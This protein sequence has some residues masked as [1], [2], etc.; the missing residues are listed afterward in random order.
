VD[1]ISLTE[2]RYVFVIEAKRSSLA[3]A[4]KQCLLAMKDMGDNNSDGVVYG[5][6]TTGSLWQMMTYDGKSWSL[7]EQFPSLFP[8]MRADRE[9]W[10]RDY[11]VLV[12]CVYAALT[13][14]G[15]V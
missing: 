3:Q 11:S 6:I 5:L 2:E 7:T 13:G 1:R 10:I 15:L 12:D 8:R 4:L 9:R 14:G